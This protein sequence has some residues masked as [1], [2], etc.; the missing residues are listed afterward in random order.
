MQHSFAD[1]G[2]GEFYFTTLPFVTVLLFDIHVV[3][4][5]DIWTFAHSWE[6]FEYDRALEILQIEWK[7]MNTSTMIARTS[8]GNE[9]ELI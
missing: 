7:R 4:I 9:L 5:F 3:L 8:I 6:N 1:E 2:E